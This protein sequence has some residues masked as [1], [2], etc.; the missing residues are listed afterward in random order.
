[1]IRPIIGDLERKDHR[2]SNRRI[3][4]IDHFGDPK[5][6]ADRPYIRLTRIVA[7]KR[8]RLVRMADK[9]TIGIGAGWFDRGIDPEGGT[10]S[11]R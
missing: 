3:R 8:I 10:R 5:I 9:N 7:T 11:Q 4:L 1:M 2:T 6:C